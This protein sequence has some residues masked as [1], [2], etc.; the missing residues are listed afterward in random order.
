MDK[1]FVLA[2]A[3]TVLFL[4]GYQYFIAKYYPKQQPTIEQEAQKEILQPEEII[5]EEEVIFEQ[6]V[7]EKEI[8]LPSVGI[9]NFIVTYSATGGYIKSI[10]WAQYDDQLLFENIGYIPKDKDKAF[11]AQVQRN[12]IIFNSASGEKKEFIFEGNS[13]TIKL[14]SSVS[15]IVLFYNPLDTSYLGQRYQELFYS[16]DK[17]VLR[18]PLKKVKDSSFSNIDFAGSRNRYYCISLLPGDYNIQAVKK[19]DK[20]YL[21]LNSPSRE[22]SLYVGPQRVEDLQ[23]FGL[24]GVVNYG[25]FHAIA[26]AIIKLLYFFH[27]FTKSWGLSVILFSITAYLVL[28]PLTLKS[29]KGMKE[30]RE[31]QKLHKSEIDKIKEKHKGNQHKI[32]EATMEMYK[33][34][35]F[36]PLRGCASGCLPMFFQIPLIW[37][38]W[39]VTPRAWMFKGAKFLW[40]K[41]LSLPDKAIHLP[42]TIPFGLGDWLNILPILTAIAMFLQMRFA[43]PHVDPEQEQ[44]QKMM[45]F[46]FPVM[47]G[48]FTYNLPSALL[49]YWFTNSIVTF[50]S[51]WKIM[52]SNS[53]QPVSA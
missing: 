42:F 14:S 21:L 27:S 5:V 11:S 30:M 26:I 38:F 1:R 4:L 53:S 51:Q 25:F 15:S 17:Q 8:S 23:V 16:K 43:N 50:I 40:I 46:L 3:L 22:I 37:A 35:G 44:Q 12:K 34:Y 45:A 29:S 9:G 49:L 19:D 6:E 2:I 32:H 7:A 39:S 28:F 47:I 20:V 31:F 33:K 41:D 13:L 36:N 10:K 52:R 18:Q 24:Q 48:W